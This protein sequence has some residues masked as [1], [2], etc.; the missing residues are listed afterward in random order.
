MEPLTRIG[1]AVNRSYDYYRGVLRGIVRYAEARPRWL[2]TS[3]ATEQRSRQVLGRSR[4][5]GLIASVHSPAL[6]RAFSGWR[7]R[8]HVS[9]SVTR[10]PL[11]STSGSGNWKGGTLLSSR[12]YGGPDLGFAAGR[13]DGGAA[14]SRT[15]TQSRSPL[16]FMP[17]VVNLRVPELAKGEPLMVL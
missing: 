15:S 6:V 11:S 17:G 9:A 1:L 8:V 14:V 10:N 3:V 2:F 4:V 12:F 13:L 16:A 5:A 7:F